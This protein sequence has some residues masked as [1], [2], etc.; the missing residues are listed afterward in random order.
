V[1]RYR[2]LDRRFPWSTT[3]P[4][5]FHQLHTLPEGEAGTAAL[6]RLLDD[7]ALLIPRFYP[8]GPTWKAEGGEGSRMWGRDHLAS[9]DGSIFLSTCRPLNGTAPMHGGA[10]RGHIPTLAFDLDDLASRG[11]I[12]WRPHD[13][14][15]VYGNLS[16]LLDMDADGERASAADRRKVASLLQGVARY[17]TIWNLAMARRLLVLEARALLAMPDPGGLRVEAE[18]ALQERTGGPRRRERHRYGIYW[19][20]FIDKPASTG[21]AFPDV[22]EFT[23]RPEILVAGSVPVRLARF[24]FA[25]GADAVWEAM[26][27]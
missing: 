24:R 13:L 20:A 6:G 3:R 14:F 27:R 23:S 12:G 11:N 18:S 1:T 19:L 22:L 10:G 21:K 9:D 17:G 8:Q 15:N 16:D 25:G 26:P 5:L 2:L 4:L 7:D